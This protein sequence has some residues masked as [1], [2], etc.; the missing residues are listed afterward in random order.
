VREAEL[1]PIA[2]SRAL[3]APPAARIIRFAESFERVGSRLWPAFSGLILLEA[4]KQTF[5]LKPTTARLPARARAPIGLRPAPA[6][7]EAPKG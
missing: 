5:A 4:V 1:E 3:Y 7:R 2:W 6:A